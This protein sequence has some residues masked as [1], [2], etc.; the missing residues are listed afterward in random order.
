M[1]KNK[2][3]YSSPLDALIAISKRLSIFEN[4]YQMDSEVFSEK[5]LKGQMDDS[6]DIIE[7]ANDYE[8]YISIRRNLEGQL[9]NVA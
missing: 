7:W 9:R 5:Y 4:R 2:T 3:E 8:H 6:A 1:K